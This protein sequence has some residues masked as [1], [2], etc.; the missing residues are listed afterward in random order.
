[1][2][3]AIYTKEIGNEI[4]RLT[5]SYCQRWDCYPAMVCYSEREELLN[6]IKTQNID[7]AI[8]NGSRDD[9]DSIVGETKKMEVLTNF[10]WISSDD[11]DQVN[12]PQSVQQIQPYSIS[13]ERKLEKGLGACGIPSAKESLCRVHLQAD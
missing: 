7:I 8:L 12:Q 10:I 3:I 13:L 11:V 9:G 5:M 2:K 1:M 6:A 4:F